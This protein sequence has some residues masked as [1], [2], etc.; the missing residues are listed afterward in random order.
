MDPT[1]ADSYT[2]QALVVEKTETVTDPNDSEKTWTRLRFR[3]MDAPAAPPPEG[4]HNA[5][6]PLC[7]V[8][9]LVDPDFALRPGDAVEMILHK[10]I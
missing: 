2:R 5:S 7:S 3:G 1:P 9:V 6:L 10:V 8:H 4:A